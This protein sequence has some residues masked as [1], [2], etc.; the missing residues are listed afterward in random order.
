MKTALPS[1]HAPAPL[2]R[3]AAPPASVP[4][5]AADPPDSFLEKLGFLLLCV[6]LFLAFSRVA[7]FVLPSLHLPLVSSLM[8]LGAVFLSGGVQRALSSSVGKLLVVFT[9]WLFFITPFGYWRGGSVTLLKDTWIKSFLVYFLIAGLIRT[10][11]HCRRVMF[12]LALAGLTVALISLL[13]GSRLE[14]RLVVSAGSLAN[15]NVIAFLILIT[16]PF[17]GVVAL[18]DTHI[19]FRRVMVGLAILP[20]FGAVLMTGS[21][22]ALV[23]LAVL[24][25]TFFLFASF[26]NKLKL[27]FVFLVAVV[28][29]SLLVPDTLV[30]RY[31]TIVGETGNQRPNEAVASKMQRIA[32]VKSSIAMTLRHPFFGVGPGNFQ[33]AS[34]AEAKDRGEP[35][36]W[37]ETHNTYTQVSSETGIPGFLLYISILFLSLRS[38]V[39]LYKQSRLRPDLP[40]VA[41]MAFC[42]LASLLSFCAGALFGSSA[43]ELYVPALAG[44]AVAFTAVAQRAL[45]SQPAPAAAPVSCP[46]PR[47]SVRRPFPA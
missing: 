3:A 34:A 16:A 14:G 4:A 46:A 9:V 18:N 11:R 33:P 36:F 35:I 29:A 31:R 6:F 44:L 28:L 37:R 8:A 42:L 12:V 20:M 47:P 22:A 30:E 19:P 24:G 17:W 21:R 43:Y 32:L 15:S 40:G 7:D 38:T 41:G 2:S 5:A 39:R 25:V 10:L 23:V 27:F 26:A 45:Q 1:L 13:F